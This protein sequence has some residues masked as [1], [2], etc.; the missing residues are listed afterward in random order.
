MSDP[1]PGRQ[2]LTDRQLACLRH[3]ADGLTAVETAKAL[4]ASRGV[5]TNELERIR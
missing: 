3:A 5:V 4:H 1:T 2:Q